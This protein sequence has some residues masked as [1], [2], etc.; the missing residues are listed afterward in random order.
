MPS[1]E[2]DFHRARSVKKKA[3]R[4]TPRKE[5]SFHGARP[6]KKQA[7]RKLA[8]KR[9]GFFIKYA[10]LTDVFLQDLQ[11]NATNMIIKDN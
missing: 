6:V 3:S 11:K 2:A 9:M 10:L 8:S 7:S 4:S 1:K 5:T